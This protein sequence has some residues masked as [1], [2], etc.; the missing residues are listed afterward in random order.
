MVTPRTFLVYTCYLITYASKTCTLVSHIWQTAQRATVI[1][2]SLSVY[3]VASNPR[4][5]VS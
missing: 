2:I 3:G 4:S 1:G 5:H